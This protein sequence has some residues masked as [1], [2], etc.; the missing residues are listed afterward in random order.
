LF[1]QRPS[2]V[3]QLLPTHASQAGLV[4]TKEP[5]DVPPSIAPQTALQEVVLQSTRLS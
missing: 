1:E 4:K 5:Q 2:S 3:Q